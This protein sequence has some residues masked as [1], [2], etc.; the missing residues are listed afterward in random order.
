MTMVPLDKKSISPS[1]HTLLYSLVKLEDMHIG[2][3]K[4]MRIDA[5]RGDLGVA[6]SF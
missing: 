2:S 6:P 1:N 3:M 5:S 4:L